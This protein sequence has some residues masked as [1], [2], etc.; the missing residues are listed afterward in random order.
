MFEVFPR[1][2]V[3]AAEKGSTN[4]AAHTMEEAGLLVADQLTAWI[5]HG[6]MLASNRLPWHPAN[7][8]TLGRNFLTNCGCPGFRCSGFLWVE[9]FKA[10][11]EQLRGDLSEAL[12]Q[13]AAMQAASVHAASA[14][15]AS[16]DKHL[17]R[18]ENAGQLA[19]Y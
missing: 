1:K 15:Q 16:P 4:A 17:F 3:D 18:V 5:G 19:R 6:S 11:F 7:V 10:A 9:A 8:V 14:Q 12:D 2:L 13:Q